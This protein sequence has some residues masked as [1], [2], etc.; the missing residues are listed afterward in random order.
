MVDRGYGGEGVLPMLHFSS[1]GGGA[2]LFL[3][4]ATFYFFF[5][6][7]DGHPVRVSGKSHRV[8]LHEDSA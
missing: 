2:F 1:Q 3:F 6:P 4:H 8:R 5:G 7:R